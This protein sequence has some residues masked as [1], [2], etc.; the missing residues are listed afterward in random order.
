VNNHHHEDQLVERMANLS[1][2][3]KEYLIAALMRSKRKCRVLE[4][5]IQVLDDEHREYKAALD[6]SEKKNEELKEKMEMYEYRLDL[7]DTVTAE[8]EDKEKEKQKE[9][10]IQV[11]EVEEQEAKLMVCKVWA[12]RGRCRHGHEGAICEHGYHP[13]R[14]KLE[15]ASTA[16]AESGVVL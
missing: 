11:N 13:P 10:T 4:D 5:E 15:V 8:G 9:D 12:Q 3:S 2:M 16:E 1:L 6:E 7:V 14:E